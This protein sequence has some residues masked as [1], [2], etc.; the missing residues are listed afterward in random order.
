MLANCLVTGGSDE[1]EFKMVSYLILLK[2]KLF[3]MGV[4]TE[5]SII[6]QKNKHFYIK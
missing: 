1:I 6:S 2:Q 3:K 5:F 4:N